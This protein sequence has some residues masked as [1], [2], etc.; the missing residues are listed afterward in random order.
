MALEVNDKLL[1]YTTRG[2]FHSPTRD[3][4]RVMGLAVAT[5]PV[6]D[7]AEP[8]V[9]GERRYTLGCALA[10]QGVAALR[11]GVN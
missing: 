9:F 11:E 5:T 4:G 1:I 6:H 2:C 3:A 8:V 10:I 7:L